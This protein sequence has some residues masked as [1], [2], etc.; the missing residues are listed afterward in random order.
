MVD[1]IFCVVVSNVKITTVYDGNLILHTHPSMAV[2]YV[3]LYTLSII[4][5][6]EMTLV[7]FTLKCNDPLKKILGSLKSLFDQVELMY[8]SNGI[9]I[10][11]LYEAT[12]SSRKNRRRETTSSV[13]A[14]MLIQLVLPSDNINMKYEC[15]EE[16]F[17]QVFSVMDLFEIY[18]ST[19]VKNGSHLLVDSKDQLQVKFFDSQKGTEYYNGHVNTVS[20]IKELYVLYNGLDTF[21]TNYT[22]SVEQFIDV[23]KSIGNMVKLITSTNTAWYQW[24]EHG[25]YF[26][27]LDNNQN[28]KGYQFIGDEKYKDDEF[29]LGSPDDRKRLPRSIIGFIRTC[30]TTAEKK[31]KNSIIQLL[32]G[33]SDEL[34]LKITL[35]GEIGTINAIIL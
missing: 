11:Q 3:P 32:R 27:V 30:L 31:K 16:E 24:S 26:F 13:E 8:S 1:D 18:R 35:R 14:S 5:I 9:E 28:L 7:S 34:L 19:G 23:I 4:C 17:S 12:S 29:E 10:S 15:D 25:I 20:S 2:G 6:G 33:D 21:K 22:T